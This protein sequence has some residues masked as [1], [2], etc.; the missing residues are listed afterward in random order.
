MRFSLNVPVAASDEVRS[1][2]LRLAAF[3]MVPV[4][5]TIQQ[6]DVMVMIDRCDGARSGSQRRILLL[7]SLLPGRAALASS[8]E[9]SLSLP[10]PGS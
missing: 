2:A 1:D 10:Q 4:A 5:A 7:V 8:T 6:V 9:E 3:E